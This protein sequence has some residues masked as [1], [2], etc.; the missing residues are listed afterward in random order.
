MID[1]DDTKPELWGAFGEVFALA[2]GLRAV[3]GDAAHL[4]REALRTLDDERRRLRSLGI[5]LETIEAFEAPVVALVDESGHGHF[6][7]E[8]VSVSGERFGHE[9]FGEG[10]FLTLDAL[11]SAPESPSPLL[12]A[13][14]RALTL[15]FRGRYALGD[16]AI[17]KDRIESLLALIDRRTPPSQPS[18]PGPPEPAPGGLTSLPPPWL[19]LTAWGIATSLVC[20]MRLSSLGRDLASLTLAFGAA[21]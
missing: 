2:Q 5:D 16:D 13:Y 17:L 9:T 3:E 15:G 20:L 19:I 1:L 21:P 18:E 11:M 4:R 7:G 14:A 12:F 8:W 10:F 6:P